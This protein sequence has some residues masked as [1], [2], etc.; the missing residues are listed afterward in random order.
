MNE[1][2]IHRIVTEVIS[3]LARRVGADGTS[4]CLVFVFTGATV[5]LDEAV[6][7]A[8]S[9][10]MMGYRLKLAFT[11]AAQELCGAVVEDRMAGFPHVEHVDPARWLADL[12]TSCGIVSPL[13]SVNT[14][15]KVALLIANNLA[16]NLI[17]HGLFMGKP[18]V[19]ARNGVDPLSPGR[20]ALGF[21]R[22]SEAL[23]RAVIDRLRVLSEYGCHLTDIRE[24]AATTDA[25]VKKASSSKPSGTTSDPASRASIVGHAGKVVAAASI[26]RAVQ[27][28]ANVRISSTSV[29][30]PA[31]RDLALRHGVQL[32]LQDD[33]RP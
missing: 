14:A 13:L 25:L 16:A 8:R 3:R 2:L 18:V 21:D 12:R 32:V 22:G 33:N 10:I 5:G 17:L 9:L 30:T 1:Q 26:R 23:N 6:G 4:G 29:V 7:Q 24:L 27:Q 15:S 19:M 20:S 31:A 11:K 28:G